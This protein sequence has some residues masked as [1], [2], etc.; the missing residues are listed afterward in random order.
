VTFDLAALS[1]L[2]GSFRIKALFEGASEINRMA[3]EKF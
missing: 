3:S 2:I 1:D